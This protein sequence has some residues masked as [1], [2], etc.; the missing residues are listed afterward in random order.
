MS[1]D[2]RALLRIAFSVSASFLLSSCA[3]LA[4][5]PITSAS[6]GIWGATGKG[7]ADH[8]VSYAMSEDCV[9]LRAINSEPICQSGPRVA[10]EVIDKSLSIATNPNH[11][12]PQSHLK[13]NDVRSRKRVIENKKN[14]KKKLLKKKVVKPT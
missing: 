13:L 5:Y 14:Q 10:P 8:A 9:T 4:E 1:C 6:V 2:T 11:T 7:P 3:L 12:A